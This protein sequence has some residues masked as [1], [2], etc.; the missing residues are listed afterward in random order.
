M[1]RLAGS[2][3]GAPRIRPAQTGDAADV[4]ALLQELGYPCSS[5]EAGERIVRVLQEPRMFLLLAETDNQVC[6]LLALDIL[7]SIARGSD[8]ARITA[9]VVAGRCARQGIGRQLLREAEAIAR[10][11]RVARVEV[12][13]NARREGAHAF[14][15]GCGYGEGSRHFIKLLGD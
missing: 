7:Y 13:T 4:A 2:P 15:Q 9:L 8:Q 11:A 1:G 14:Y 5:E 10:Q 3:I 6:G 12:T